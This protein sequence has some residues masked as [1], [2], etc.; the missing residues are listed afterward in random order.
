MFWSKTYAAI[1]A[2]FVLTMGTAIAQPAS[3][4]K[5]ETNPQSKSGAT[6]VVHPTED[7]CRKGWN[8][9]LRWTKEQFEA[10]CSN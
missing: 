10:F 7:E 2:A 6:I 3:P 1:A 8:A 5:P 4:P 9:S